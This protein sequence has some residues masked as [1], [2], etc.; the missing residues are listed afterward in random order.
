MDTDDGDGYSVFPAGV[1][2]AVVSLQTGPQ[3]S[4]SPFGVTATVKDP[5][6]PVAG[7]TVHFTVSQNNTELFDYAD[8]SA[9]DG[10]VVLRLPPGQA[11]PSGTV[12][13]RA[14]LIGASGQVVGSQ[15]VT[16]QIVRTLTL[17]YSSATTLPAGQYPVL[18]ATLT[19]AL[20]PVAGVPVT[21]TLPGNAPGAVFP[22]LKITA[23]ATTDAHGVATAPKM[24]SRLVVGTFA[25][26]ASAPN[27]TPVT[28]AMATQYL[29]SPFGAPV[30]LI[31]TTSVGLTATLKLAALVLQP[32]QLIPDATAKSLVAAQRVQL[33]WR[34]TSSTGAWTARNDLVTYDAKKHTFNAS[35]V[36]KSLGMVKG[37]TYTV[38]M[39]I[40]VGPGDVKPP[41]YDA[42]S[43]SFD[44][45]GNQFTLK[46]T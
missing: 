45:G 13:V 27:A 46:L 35:L 32:I 44:L 25:V 26:T 3:T 38:Q 21:F 10:T 28:A 11:L 42:V 17:G 39:R 18:K 43:G 7:R 31:G 2:Q 6:G 40:L 1:D 22:G 29:V 36:G 4:A 8:S 19:N 15:S 33:R 30:K 16:V 14:D 9:A 34:P 41:G 12:N 37:Q 24:T 23:T 20:G 5:S